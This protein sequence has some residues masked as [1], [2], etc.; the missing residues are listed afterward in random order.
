MGIMQNCEL[1]G[2]YSDCGILWI[3]S[4]WSDWKIIN[5]IICDDCKNN[6]HKKVKKLKS[7]IKS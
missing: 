4:N 7:K 5:L 2:K 1:C 3:D 6:F